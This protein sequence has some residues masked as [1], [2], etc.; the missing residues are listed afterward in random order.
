M[1]AGLFATYVL[2]TDLPVSLGFLL[3]ETELSCAGLWEWREARRWRDGQVKS[4]GG[5]LEGGTR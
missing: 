1:L 3:K 2:T 5:T 4:E